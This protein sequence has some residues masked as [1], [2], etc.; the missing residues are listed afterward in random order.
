M[1]T[2]AGQRIATVAQEGLLRRPRTPR[3]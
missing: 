3:S 1:L 2:P